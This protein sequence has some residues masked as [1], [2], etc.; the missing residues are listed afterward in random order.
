MAEENIERTEQVRLW[1]CRTISPNGV[2]SDPALKAA[3]R[4]VE[5][6]ADELSFWDLVMERQMD[7]GTIPSAMSLFDRPEAVQGEAIMEDIVNEL[8][9]GITDELL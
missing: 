2:V 8:T 5:Q 9:A 1:W 3:Q 7:A 6:E 4:K